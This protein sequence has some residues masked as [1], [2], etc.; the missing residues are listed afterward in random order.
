MKMTERATVPYIQNLHQKL[1]AGDPTASQ[2]LAQIL[3]PLL[4]R[5]LSKIF[6]MVDKDIIS[7]GVTDAFLEY[8]IKPESFDPGKNVPVD[9][10][11]LMA[12]RRNVS[13]VLRSEKRRRDREEKYAREEFVEL[14]D[15]AGNT[16][17]EGRNSDARKLSHLL[18]LLDD[19]KDKQILRLKLAGERH[20]EA[21]SK[22]LGISDLPVEVQRKEVKRAKDRIEKILRRHVSRKEKN[23]E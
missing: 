12:A 9:R 6:P 3:L 13:N 1:S 16:I 19:P 10:F 14:A 2:E 11:L 21:F 8:C 20:T 15:F 18:G 22:V 7:D 5:Q 4:I 17:G 23:N